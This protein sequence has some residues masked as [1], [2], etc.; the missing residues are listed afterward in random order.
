MPELTGVFD[1]G[2]VTEMINGRAQKCGL[3]V[4]RASEREAAPTDFYFAYPLYLQETIFKYFSK[5]RKYRPPIDITQH[6]PLID[7]KEFIEALEGVN[8]EDICSAE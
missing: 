1:G 4:F 5:I 6:R 2:E 7:R 8:K 3:L